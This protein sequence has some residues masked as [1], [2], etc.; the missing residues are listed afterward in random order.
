MREAFNDYLYNY[1]K[2]H[3]FASHK[4]FAKELGIS[5]M[6]YSMYERG[7]IQP[8]GKYKEIIEKYTGESLDP[9]L[10]GEN[11]YPAAMKPKKNQVLRGLSKLFRN[12]IARIITYVITA[13]GIFCIPAAFIVDFYNDSSKH[14]FYND[15]YQEIYQKVKD[16]GTFTIDVMGYFNKREIAI[17]QTGVYYVTVKAPVS[18]IGM[19]E[20]YY[21]CTIRDDYLRYNI[22]YQYANRID[23]LLSDN[24]TG[25]YWSYTLN[26]T[27]TD[28]FTKGNFAESRHY[29]SKWN[30][31]AARDFM[32][33]KF[34]PLVKQ[35]DNLFGELFEVA[36]DKPSIDFY[37]DVLVV[38][39]SGDVKQHN[40]NTAYNL[41][42]F[43]GMPLGIMG[44]ALILLWWLY[45]YPERK[46][47]LQLKE[48]DNS[49]RLPNEIEAMP[50]PTNRIRKFFVGEEVIRVVGAIFLFVGSIRAILALVTQL[51]VLTLVNR[52]LDSEALLNA[53]V[54]IFVLGIF[55]NY[56]METDSLNDRSRLFR[57]IVVYGFLAIVIGALQSAAILQL[58]Y[59]GNGIVYS[60][61]KFV[62]SNVFGIIFMFFMIAVFLYYLPKKF[63]GKKKLT[64]MWRWFSLVP[65]LI[66]LSLY[67]VI[68]VAPVIWNFTPNKYIAYFFGVE[69]LPFAI[70]TF[71]YL[72][73][74]YFMR[75]YYYHKYG[76]HQAEIF[77][78]GERYNMIK[79]IIFSS[80]ALGLGIIE[81]I[82][83]FVFP[84][85]AYGL[86]QSFYVIFLAP[87]FLF[88]KPRNGDRNLGASIAASA[89]YVLAIII[90]YSLAIALFVFYGIT[91]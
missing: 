82:F 72:Y 6:R 20:I 65:V 22:K 73:S 86:G 39:K 27:G 70:L 46:I 34:L 60:L 74:T 32:D 5:P 52:T 78:R 28:T 77:F 33:N 11:S 68:H 54:N 61:E 50:L 53:F 40:L 3:G 75:K 47:S 42:A 7:Y 35:A 36:F 63:V 2:Q 45:M 24:G 14:N 16:E 56:I 10:I 43:I 25:E 23:F 15:N 76:Y 9:Y 84:G 30:N 79:N 81:L 51:G 91:R 1:R 80:S 21:E 4:K 57:N 59:S 67:F 89:L 83:L 69:R 48:V 29:V 55:L 58:D 71:I 62:P 31:A 38:K 41:L 88:F 37:N 90:Y 19:D 49:D 13:I 17:H 64:L 18:S 12:R 26:R 44:A 8:Q 66:V 87:I 85:N